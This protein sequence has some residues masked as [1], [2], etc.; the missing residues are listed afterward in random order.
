MPTPWLEK[1]VEPCLACIEEVTCTVDVG[2]GRTRSDITC[3]DLVKM[4]VGPAHYGLDG[5]MQPVEPNV[6]R[7]LDA[8]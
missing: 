5:K 1:V 6:E 8:A 7:H 4:T 3:A 2:K